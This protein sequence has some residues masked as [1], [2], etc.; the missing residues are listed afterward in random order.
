MN[1][2]DREAVW[3]KTDGHCFYCDCPL[4]ADNQRGN[5]LDAE[6][7]SVHWMQVDHVTP[8]SQR[9]NHHID[10]LVPSCGPC[11]A[12][13]GRKNLEEYRERMARAALSMPTFTREQ[14]DWL[15]E[16]GFEFP[17]PRS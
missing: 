8:V 17:P 9:G 16:H 13:K 4:V 10:N 3:Q 1:N 5:A 12:Q 15:E 14:V 7:K 6:G 2:L 11:N